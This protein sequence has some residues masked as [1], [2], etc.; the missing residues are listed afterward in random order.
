MRVKV[1]SGRK[2][3][4]ETREFS[5]LLARSPTG[6]REHTANLSPASSS[7]RLG[8]RLFPVKVVTKQ[9]IVATFDE[10]YNYPPLETRS[11]VLPVEQLA[12][13]QEYFMFRMKL[14]DYV[15]QRP[16]VAMHVRASAN[17]WLR[18]LCG[19]GT[20]GLDVLRKVEGSGMRF[21]GTPSL[22]DACS[23][24]RG[25]NGYTR[26]TQTITSPCLSNLCS[27]TYGARH[28]CCVGRLSPRV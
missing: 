26:R 1:V 6:W 3:D 15:E 16:G 5:P 20:K 8:Q 9:G 4:V 27:A 11:F 25:N 18:R 10:N 19:V 2:Q 17:L 24:V 12:R 13:D 23:S 28:T 14:S 7:S 22:S 21:D